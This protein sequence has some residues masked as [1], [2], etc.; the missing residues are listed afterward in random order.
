CFGMHAF[1]DFG[2]RLAVVTGAASGIGRD[3]MLALASKGAN[4]AAC[5]LNEGKLQTVVRKVQRLYPTVRVTAH[6]CDVSDRLNVRQ[7]QNEVASEHNT[8]C[9]HFLFNNAGAVG[10]M[11]FVSSP[12]EEWERTFAVSWFGTYNCTRE[13]MPMLLAADQGAVV[14]T[15]SVNALWAS[16][17]SRTPH[18]AYSSAKFAV[19]GFTESLVVDFQRNAPHLS[20]VLVLAGHV[21]TGMPAPPRTWRRA[22][23]GEFADYEPVSSESAASIILEAVQRGEWRVVIG[24]DAAAV[25]AR[26]RADP[27]SVYD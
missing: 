25:D 24:D 3:L 11:S 19:R 20:A 14:N 2:G 27:W 10:G 6:V 4:V 17:G 12:P 21:S 13:F 1:E 22:L 9:V 5:D 18:S 23:D 7:F 15:A 8:D 26:V 16:L